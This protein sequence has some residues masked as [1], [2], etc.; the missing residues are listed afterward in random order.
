[1]TVYDVVKKLIGPIDPVGA[2][3][4]DTKRFENLAAMIDLTEALLDDLYSVSCYSTR[5]E[6]SMARA[7]K[8]AKAVFVNIIGEHG[9]IE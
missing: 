6:A 8:K 3:H 4:V 2:E 5:Q 9:E 1:M 7:G